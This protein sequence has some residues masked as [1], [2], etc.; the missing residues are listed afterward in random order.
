MY[1]KFPMEGLC[2]RVHGFDFDVG[3]FGVMEMGGL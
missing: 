2:T 3:R 1:V